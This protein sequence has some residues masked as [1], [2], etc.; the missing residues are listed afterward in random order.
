MPLSKQKSLFAE[1]QRK[2]LALR[3]ANLLDEVDVNILALLHENK[4]RSSEALAQEISSHHPNT[5][6][7]T[8]TLS[9]DSLL[10]RDFLVARASNPDHA[11]SAPHLTNKARKFLEECDQLICESN[12][13]SNAPGV[14]Y[15]CIPSGAFPATYIS[16][17]TL[18]LFGFNHK[19]FLLDPNF[20]LDHIHPIDKKLVLE[21]LS[22]LFT[23][24]THI[25]QYRFKT[26]ENSY[27]WVEDRLRLTRDSDGTPIEITGFM[28]P[29]ARSLFNTAELENLELEQKEFS[30]LY[31]NLME[32]KKRQKLLVDKVNLLENYTVNTL[33]ELS[34]F[35]DDETSSHI[36]RTQNYVEVI[37][38][39][40]ESKGQLENKTPNFI[41]DLC[42]AA[43]LHDV[44]K[45]FI[46]DEILKKP[47]KL[48]S[49][50]WDVM[51]THATLGQELLKNISADSKSPSGF[52]LRAI[53]ITGNHHENWD[54]TG[55]PLGISKNDI[56]QSAR[57]MA[58]AD[59]FDALISK[60]HYKA[61]WSFED[62]FNE[63]TK[64]SGLKFDP[65]VV[66]ALK[67]SCDLIIEIAQMYRD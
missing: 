20:W 12:K 39:Y 29:M 65:M 52:I 46:P 23:N 38:R 44:G 2:L 19:E 14:L 49:N 51:K 47:G 62:A 67:E 61:A 24:G 13:T 9:I 17:N 41:F 32:E 1:V 53:E 8:I 57:I 4:Y 50:E 66:E 31:E 25:H 37:A 26:A 54:G 58:V 7:A 42:K 60:R 64:Q 16:E 27:V 21:N 18:E 48:D 45:I 10:Q 3:A 6:I 35:K 63:I 11:L 43:P 56:P 36:T 40:L 59:C 55:Y 22:A 34:K 30:N 15:T 33:L 5:S 28:S